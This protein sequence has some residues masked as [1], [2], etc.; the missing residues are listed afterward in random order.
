MNNNEVKV[1][2]IKRLKFNYIN[3]TK[4]ILIVMLSLIPISFIIFAN[5][6]LQVKIFI[7][8]SFIIF[9]YMIIKQSFRGLFLYEYIYY[10]LIFS[11]RKKT[12]FLEESYIE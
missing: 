5:L 11:F 12:Y 8:A 7:S 3:I 9:F 10:F 4:D 6:I 1:Y 2:K